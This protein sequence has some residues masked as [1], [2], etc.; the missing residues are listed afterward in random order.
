MSFVKY[1]GRPARLFHRQLSQSLT[2]LS[3]SLCGIACV[4]NA[5]QADF[6]KRGPMLITLS[7]QMRDTIR[8]IRASAQEAGMILDVYK[9]A[10]E[11][12]NARPDE[13]VA[14]EDIVTALLFDRG[15][16]FGAYVFDSRDNIIEVV[17]PAPDSEREQ[18]AA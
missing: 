7:Q 1:A 11:A 4:A 16:T 6:R 8:E 13:S 15:S 5:A 12:Q 9:A 17:F 2:N 3:N 10:K 14:L 18:A